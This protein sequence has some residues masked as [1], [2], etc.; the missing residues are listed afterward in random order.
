MNK[1]NIKRIIAREGLVLLGIGVILYFILSAIPDIPCR[2]PKYKLVF[3]NGE[4]YILTISPE[5][6]Q[7]YNKKKFIEEA[8]NPSPQLVSK[9]IN[10]FIKDNK[11]GSEI[12][13]AKQVNYKEVSF[14]K[15]ILSFF[16]VS[17]VIKVIVIYFILFI[18]R[19]IICA[20]R[21]LRER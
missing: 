12:K 5:L 8:L 10:E 16:L 18:I 4:S 19:F 7:N 9:R 11:I 3:N 13:E 2:F 17:F 15:L 20:L 14:N 1:K 21:I 6:S